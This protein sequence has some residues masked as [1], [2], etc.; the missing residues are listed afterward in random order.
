LAAGNAGRILGSHTTFDR[1][2]CDKQPLGVPLLTERQRH[3]TDVGLLVAVWIAVLVAV[4]TTL[5][6][7]F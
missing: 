1:S 7:T 5:L 3:S 4:G 6:L 2:N